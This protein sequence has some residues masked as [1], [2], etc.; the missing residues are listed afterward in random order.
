MVKLKIFIASPSDL[1]EERDIVS[2]VVEELRRT[3]GALLEIELES[4][5][6]ENHA[7]PDVGNDA[8]D[9]IN[10]Q[11][12]EYDI[13]VGMMWKRLGTPTRRAPAGTVEEFKRA[14]EAF[15]NYNR[16]KIMFYFRTSPF[17]T[18][19]LDEIDQ[20]RKVVEFRQELTELGVF[21]WEYKHPLEFE[22]YV[23][24][25]LTKQIWR[26]STPI[27][28]DSTRTR[29]DAWV[30]R[31]FHLREHDEKLFR[32]VLS[33]LDFEEKIKPGVLI[34]SLARDNE[35]QRKALLDIEAKNRIKELGEFPVQQVLYALAF[36]LDIRKCVRFS[37]DKNLAMNFI[38]IPPGKVICNEKSFANSEPFYLAERPISEGIWNS[39]M[40]A[41]GPSNNRDRAMTPISYH[42]AE[43]FCKK[44][45]E[46]I[47]RV[48]LSYSFQIPNKSQLEFAI[49]ASKAQWPGRLKEPYFTQELPS[50]LG[51][52]DLRGVVSQ[53]CKDDGRFG[54]IG[55]W[56]DEPNPWHC[57]FKP[58]TGR[59]DKKRGIGLRLLLRF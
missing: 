54:I 36:G 56:F 58:R 42:E 16:P 17:Y 29:I 53:L 55:E 48:G 30:E 51:L 33:Y 31:L 32:D 6:W 25:H 47:R 18:T 40:N 19:D 1:K 44:A 21:F 20:F 23:R 38:L 45:T 35:R 4:L 12:S 22:R 59:L 11:I 27:T 2:S 10:K 3:L 5:R 26:L 7:W 34:E 50:L 41:E 15:K 24:E 57:L 46:H 28:L 39:L 14:Y 37:V 52:R 9:V 43:E 49:Y 13:L 8:Q